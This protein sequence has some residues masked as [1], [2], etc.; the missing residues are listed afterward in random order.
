MAI[1]TRPSNIYQEYENIYQLSVSELLL[2]PKVSPDS[3]FNDQNNWKTVFLVYEAPSSN[4]REMVEF[5]ISEGSST[6]LFEVTEFSRPSYQVKALIIEDFDSGYLRLEREDIDFVTLDIA[7]VLPPPNIDPGQPTLTFVNISPVTADASNNEVITLTFTGSEDL[8][9]VTA[10]IAGQPANVS[11]SGTSWTATYMLMGTEPA[12][13]VSFSINFEDI[14]SNAGATV[15]STTN[16]SSCTIE[17]GEVSLSAVSIT[18]TS[19]QN[20]VEGDTITV[21]FASSDPI[22]NVTSTIVGK[23]ASVSNTGGND[24][25]A[26]YT[27]TASETQ[28]QAAFTINYEDQFGNPQNQ[29]TSVTDGSQVIVDTISPTLSSVTISSNNVDPTIAESGDIITINFTSSENIQNVTSTIAGQVATVTNF[30]VNNWKSEYTVQSGDSSGVVSFTIDFEDTHGNQGSQVTSITS[31]S[32]VTIQ[33]Q[34]T[35]SPTPVLTLYSTNENIDDR[36]GGAVAMDGE[37]IVV[38]ASKDDGVSDTIQSAGE[39]YLF[40]ID[41]LNDVVLN[42]SLIN[43]PDEGLSDFFGSAVAISGNYVVVGAY[44]AE[45][46]S[47]PS[48][49]NS[50]RAYVYKIDTNTDTASHIATLVSPSEDNGN[51]FGIAVSIKDNYITIGEPTR[52]TGFFANTGYLNTYKLD[53]INDTVSFISTESPNEIRE[54]GNFGNPISMDGDYILSGSAQAEADLYHID[55]LNN[56]V[57]RVTNGFSS[58]TPGYSGND[59][60]S[61]SIHNNYITIGDPTDTFNDG[62]LFIYKIDQGSVSYVTSIA[63]P[64]NTLN[65]SFGRRVSIYDNYIAVGSNERIHVYQLN[66]SNDS[67]S[68]I[69]TIEVPFSEVYVNGDYVIVGNIVDGGST[70]SIQNAGAAYLYKIT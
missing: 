31:G 70:G 69:S 10:T 29:V 47:D 39:V 3:Y 5:F 54:A 64:D 34:F 43:S 66:K 67:S 45:G 24:W 38:G 13:P 48:L 28:G 2:H 20:A 51:N 21:S 19:G 40:K 68:I 27:L 18:S 61:V 57:S 52:G 60:R 49:Y 25:E 32:N 8:Q 6:G 46:A 44:A 59:Q 9:N 12:G 50:G 1:V 11:G 36:F 62:I 26:T 7:V 53:T 22:Q 63:N 15:T 33:N 58:I 4:Q 17:Y 37:Y 55:K 30:S 23:T 56:T 35:V 65:N 42:T 16:G 41:S 14:D